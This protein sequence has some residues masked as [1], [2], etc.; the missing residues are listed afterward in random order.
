MSGHSKWATIKRQKEANDAKRGQLFS[1]LAR[2]ISLVAKQGGPSP[3]SN[4]Q[5]RALMDKARQYNMPK[6]NIQR[7]IEKG[8]G[9]GGEGLTEVTYEGYGPGG[10][11]V[12]VEAA[13]DNKNRTAQEVKKI[14]ERAG[15]SLASPGSVSFQ[16]ERA[17][18]I[19]VEKK[20]NLDEQ[21]LSIMDIT[22]VEDLA[23]VEDGIEVYTQPGDVF[24]VREQAEKGGMGVRSAEITY[25]PKA[26]VQISGSPAGQRALKLLETLDEHDDV[27]RVYANID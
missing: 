8:V 6:E 23:V 26:L 22:G 16:F 11:A 3:D 21:A 5:L 10:V 1:K 25:K 7:A 19:L 20:D 17:G 13:T 2:A 4:L 18:Q 27:Q 12:M 14:F 24:K 9:A 15:G